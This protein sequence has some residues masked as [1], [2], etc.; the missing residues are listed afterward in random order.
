M[1]IIDKVENNPLQ[2]NGHPA[3]ATE[4]DL[5]TNKYR[6]MDVTT[7]SFCAVRSVLFA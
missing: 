3:W 2:V 5:A 4:Y 6:A 1:Y 7:N